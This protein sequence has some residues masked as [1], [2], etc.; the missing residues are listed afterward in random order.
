[1]ASGT[2]KNCQLIFPFLKKGRAYGNSRFN[3]IL[4]ILKYFL[5]PIMNR[6]YGRTIKCSTLI[7]NHSVYHLYIIKRC[8]DAEFTK[9]DRL[10]ICRAGKMHVVVLH[11]SPG[12]WPLEGTTLHIIVTSYLEHARLN[13]ASR[14]IV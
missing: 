6:T 2:K 10:D 12:Q 14:G 13:E 5:T 11:S 7:L 8:R 4:E 9:V 1:M 3:K